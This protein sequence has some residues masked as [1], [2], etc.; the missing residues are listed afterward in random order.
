MDLDAARSRLG[1]VCQP[2][3]V[4][5]PRLSKFGNQPTFVDNKRFASKHEANYYTQLKMAKAMDQ[6]RGFACQVSIP[7]PSGRRRMIIDFM[8]I[9]L[10]GRVRWVD[11]KGFA[12]PEW[13]T[14]QVELE[15]S[16]G[17]R[18]ETI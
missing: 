13:K 18:I 8:I 16:L 12:T 2:K 15:H 6:I 10:D 11:T 3:Y 5:K 17:I 4:P 9:E 1:Q 7:L 14:K